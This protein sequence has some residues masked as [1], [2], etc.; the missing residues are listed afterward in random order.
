M[1]VNV[2]FV[3]PLGRQLFVPATAVLQSGTRQVVFVSRGQGSFEPRDVQL[4]TRTDEG[5]AVSK[6]LQAGDVVATSA[7]FLIDSESQLQAA[8]GSYAPAPPGA[9]TEMTSNA[10]WIAAE[11]T[12]DPNPA[13]KGRN[14]VQVKLTSADGKPLPGAKVSI[15]FH[16]AA[17][18][19][20]GM[21]EMN[22][23]VQ[24]NE[25]S[26]GA[27]TGPL[28]L[29]SGGTWQVTITAE[30]GG[31]LILTKRLNVTATGGM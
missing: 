11:L 1:F 13:H 15:R 8:A 16:M 19:E 9:G 3:L 14:T 4:G 18:P 22:S 23:A 17:M 26:T 31:K 12:T 28:D 30:Q 5:F 10:Q 2:R 27:Y 21:A 29:G 25:Q 6:G 24:L 20:M 7:N